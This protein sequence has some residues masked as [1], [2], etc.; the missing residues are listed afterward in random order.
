MTTTLR[1]RRY[2]DIWDAIEA[3]RADR[4]YV[5]RRIYREANKWCVDVDLFATDK[6]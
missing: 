2:D 4:G 1:V 3:A 5:V 6:A